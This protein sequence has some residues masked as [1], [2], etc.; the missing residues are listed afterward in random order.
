M[1]RL[2][3]VLFSLAVMIAPSFAQVGSNATYVTPPA[4]AGGGFSLSFTAADAN[5]SPTTANTFASENFGSADSTRQIVVVVGTRNIS[6]PDAPVTSLTIGGV[7]ASLVVRVS[8]GNSGVGFDDAEI[9]SASVPTGTSGSVVINF[10]NTPARLPISVYSVIH[11]TTGPVAT[12][13]SSTGVT[14]SLSGT[15]AIPSGG[16]SLGI[17]V[18]SGVGSTVTS[19]PSGFNIDSAQNPG[20]GNTYF[21]ASHSNAGALT[22]SQNLTFN[23]A[24]ATNSGAGAA[25]AAWG[26]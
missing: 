2:L 19:A 14:S 18:G 3:A 4:S 25:F 26:P 20:A 17:A 13:N 7:S 9:W 12:T 15:L 22:G 21:G 11:S 24:A 5:L 6:G 10:S 16:A 23:F 8:G 1:K